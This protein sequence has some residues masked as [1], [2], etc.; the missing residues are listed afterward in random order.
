[1]KTK[2]DQVLHVSDFDFKKFNLPP[3]DVGIDIVAI[4]KSGEYSAVQTKFRGKCNNITWKEFCTFDAL[5]NR[6]GPWIEKIIVTTSKKVNIYGLKC[7][8][9][10]FYGFDFFN[11]LAKEE[12]LDI[13]LVDSDT[14]DEKSIIF[15][16]KK[17]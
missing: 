13:L 6:S 14:L 10:R 11:N 17:K 3:K 15:L 8:K 9:D 16:L 2:Y 1:M 7:E 5:C 4:S 12:W